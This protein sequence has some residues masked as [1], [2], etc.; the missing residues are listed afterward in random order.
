MVERFYV[1]TPIYYVND[2]PHIGHAYTTIL[3][4]VLRRY[5]R[6]F[7]AETFFVTGVDEHGQ[8]VEQAARK[9]GL[10]PQAHCDD[11][12]RHFRDLWPTLHVEPDDFIRT[13][14]P[15]HV[16]VVQRA[17]QVLYDKGEIYQKEYEG[18][19]S[20][21]VE[22]FWTEKDL[23]DGRCPESGAEVVYLK[24]KNYWFRMSRYQQRLVDYID[25]HPDFIL[26]EHRRNEVLGFLREPL[27]DLCIS[28]PRSRLSWGIPL[29]FDED[30]VT[31]V[32]FDALLNYVT[33][34]GLWEDPQ[35]FDTWWPAVT[36]LIGKDI[37]TTHCVYWNAMLMALDLP[38]PRHFVAHGWWL[39]DD[40]KMSKSL[41]NVVDPLSLKD[42]YGPEVLRYYL[43]RDMVL[44][45]DAT[46]SEAALV[47]RNNSD[48]AND[49]G[50]LLSR[51]TR[52][53]HRGPYGGAVPE[54]GELRADDEPVVAAIEG[55]KETV[56]RLV[57][58]W[59]VHQAIEETM[60]VV[61]R[62]NKYIADTQ[63]FRVV[64]TDAARAGTILY[65]ALEGL[66][67]AAA[68]LWPVIPHKSR[69]ALDAVGWRGDVPT[70]PTLRFGDL[71]SGS[72]VAGR[73]RLFPRH[74]FEEQPASHGAPASTGVSA[75]T[76]PGET[77]AAQTPAGAESAS[78]KAMVTW[79]QFDALDL[80]VGTVAVA[81][82]VPKARKLLR[83][84]VDLGSERRQ[85]V[86]GIAAHYDPEALVGKQVVV[87]ANLQPRKIFGLRSQGM[88]LAAEDAESGKLSLLAPDAP[89]APGSRVG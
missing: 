27:Q 69:E 89:V 40:T 29:P 5:Y 72:P 44:G 54:R 50:N 75:A 61:R 73:V 37:L 38:L 12:Q 55:L 48:L 2:R 70:L 10:D 78:S 79:D 24:E 60:Q 25:S 11:M 33:A 42:R 26:P 6:L 7:G 3:A 43:M 23:V 58:A 49:F 53:V 39:V 86:A 41:G 4:D 83:L 15:R 36:H 21:A 16:R 19:Y 87:L 47:A 67:H 14:E 28:R 45:L 57:R 18:W 56:E 63:P 1:T 34:V 85:I 59:K 31:Y 80:V 88:L 17:L 35:R 62:I 74:A 65:V 51:V 77:K 76:K 64:K 22:R 68:L 52:M 20:P 9:R 32:W 82:R 66:R 71:Q 8:K 81:E 46:F 30:Y 13:T 84:E